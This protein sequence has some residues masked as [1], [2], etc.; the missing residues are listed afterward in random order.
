MGK[1]P[2]R[3]AKPAPKPVTGS[4]RKDPFAREWTPLPAV[5]RRVGFD[6]RTIR[7]YIAHEPFVRVL[8]ERWYVR[9]PA[10]LEWWERQRPRQA[11]N[12]RA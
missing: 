4:S 8:G 9:V 3:A 1:R 10:F 11:A 6:W 5:A 2:R 7:K 12:D